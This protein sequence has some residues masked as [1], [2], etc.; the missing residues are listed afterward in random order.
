MKPQQLDLFAWA[1]SRPSAEIVDFI[2][3][4][5]R[6]IY[7]QRGQPRVERGGELVTFPPAPVGAQIRRIA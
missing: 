4:V 5:V 6:Q 7:R 1:D 3:H 2:P